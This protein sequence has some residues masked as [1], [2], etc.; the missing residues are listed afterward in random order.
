MKFPFKKISDLHER[1]QKNKWVVS[2][3]IAGNRQKYRFI[4]T[5]KRNKTATNIELADMLGYEGTKRQKTEYISKFKTMFGVSDQ[6]MNNKKKLKQKKF[7]ELIKE[8][9]LAEYSWIAEQ[10]GVTHDSVKHLAVKTGVAYKGDKR[11][12]QV[13]RG[14]WKAPVIRDLYLRHNGQ[15]TP[16]E[17]SRKLDFDVNRIY[18][19]LAIYRSKGVLPRPE[20]YQYKV[21]N[22]KSN[23]MFWVK[24]AN[25]P[26]YLGPV[27]TMADLAAEQ[28]WWYQRLYDAFYELQAEGHAALVGVT[29]GDLVKRQDKKRVAD[30]FYKN[31]RIKT[32]ELAAKVRLPVP[33]VERYLHELNQ[34]LNEYDKEYYAMTREL[35][36]RDCF[37]DMGH[38]N[39]MLEMLKSRGRGQ[40]WMDSKSKI[41]DTVI[42]VMGLEAPQRHQHDVSIGMQRPKDETDAIVNA[43]KE[44]QEKRIELINMIP[45]SDGNYGPNTGE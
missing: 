5:W 36:V 4:L 21:K 32:D 24:K 2:K 16:M 23:I 31:P 45:D 41:R 34:E 13:L 43:Y 35:V 17:M 30:L 14:N 7:L 8:N 28:N 11:K 26:K 37:G 44:A 42:K 3:L 33:T 22:S 6:F 29:M 1:T 20:P 12:L 15:I 9:P 40:G 25:D 18:V 10:M 39:D 27:P 38:C 19:I